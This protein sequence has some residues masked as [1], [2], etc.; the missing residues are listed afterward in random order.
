M[1]MGVDFAAINTI[2]FENKS[3]SE[4]AALRVAVNSLEYHFDGRVA[5]VGFSNSMKEENALD[6][7]ALGSVNSLPR[8]IE[9]VELGIVIKE[10]SAKPGEFKVSMRSGE[11]VDCSVICGKLGGGGHIR[12]SGAAVKADSLNAAKEIILKTVSECIE[13]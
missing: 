5:V 6:D 4:I 7:D 9:G 2:L 1:A 11:T 12:A 10:K 3:R 8:E 13:K